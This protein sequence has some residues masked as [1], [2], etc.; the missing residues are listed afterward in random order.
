MGLGATFA[1]SWLLVCQHVCSRCLSGSLAHILLLCISTPHRTF[2]GLRHLDGLL[3][4]RL[5]LHGRLLLL[6]KVLRPLR[7][8]LLLCCRGYNRGGCGG[9]SSSS[10]PSGCWL[11]T[12]L[13]PVALL[14]GWLLCCS[15]CCN[16]VLRVGCLHLW[17]ALLVPICCNSSRRC[18]LLWVRLRSW[19]GLSACC[20]CLLRCVCCP[21]LLQRL[22]LSQDGLRLLWLLQ[23]LRIL[24][25]LS[26]VLRLLRLLR[27]VLRL[28]RLLWLLRLVV[29]LLW[30]L[31]LRLLRLLL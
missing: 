9:H 18:C 29:W 22:R 14:R 10:G 11:L 8:Q 7:C 31:V 5:L 16:S 27:L 28:L 6:C 20:S 13:E 25:L 4:L 3:R 23:L 21:L 17:R 15:Y 26:R 19:L 30:L 2:V 24:R 1:C 12:L